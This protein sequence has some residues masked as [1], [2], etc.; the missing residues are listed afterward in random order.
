[1]L[2]KNHHQTI[3]IL[4]G[5]KPGNA[6]IAQRPVYYVLR[7]TL[8]IRTLDILDIRTLDTLHSKHFKHTHS[9]LF[10]HAHSRYFAL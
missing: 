9:R 6:S 1:M 5:Y 2:N 8:D 4:T 10:R 7:Y 3:P